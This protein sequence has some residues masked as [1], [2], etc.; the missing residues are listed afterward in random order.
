MFI[1]HAIILV[2]AGDGGNGCAS[3]RREKYIPKGGPDGGDGGDGGSVIAFG[4]P[5]KQ[6]LMDFRHQHTW[7]ARRGEDG[8]GK[9]QFG[10][11]ME[12]V[13]LALPPGTIISDRDT[14]ELLADLQPGQRVVLAQGGKGGLGND[15]FKSATHQAPREFTEGRAGQQR[16]LALELKLIADIG[17]VGKPN[18]GK[19]TLLASVTRATPKIADYPFTTLTPQLGIAELDAERRLVIADIPGLIE[20]AALGVGLGHEFLR[21]IERTSVIVHLLEIDPADGSDPVENYR[22]IRAELTRY[23]PMLAEKPEI[24]ALSKMDLLGGGGEGEEGAEETR[25]AVSLIR[26]GLRLGRD[27]EVYPIS[28]ASRTGLSELLDACWRA[29]DESRVRDKGILTGEGVRE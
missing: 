16:A 1:D 11:A 24:I 12:D 19:S 7:K 10:S 27:Q 8:R 4:D 25:T 29:R 15:H 17:L 22:V 21:H 14:G 26:A 20:G 23:S 3:F 18:A 9:K 6:T 2:K 5:N 13:E 28:A